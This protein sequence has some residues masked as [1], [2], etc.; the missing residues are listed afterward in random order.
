MTPLAD[1]TN[2]R[3][4]DWIEG[5]REEV[6][7]LSG[8]RLGY[9][10]LTDF[11][12]EGSKDFVRQFYPQRDKAG[13]IFD[14]RW[15]R[16]GFTSQAV[17]DVLRR[18]LAGVFVNREEAVSPLPS[19]TAP[20]VMVTL[21]NYASASDGDQFPFFFRQFKLGNLVGE[22]TWGGVQGINGP[23]KLMDGSFITIPKDSLASLDAHWVIE[24]EG[25]APDVP[26]EPPPDEAV[27]HDDSQ[28][29]VAVKTALEQLGRNPLPMLKAPDALPAYPPGGNVPGASFDPSSSHPND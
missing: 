22:R 4:H 10:F 14:V 1:E 25:V 6:N 3:R 5:N 15:N 9:I 16:G 17:L 12:V 11:N 2:V 27:T 7:R 21:T 29:K 24:N 23:W 13:L 20:R 28:L 19:A 18:E 26:V 8:G